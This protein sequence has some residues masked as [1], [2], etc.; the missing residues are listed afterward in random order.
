MTPVDEV[1][2]V[3]EAVAVAGGVG[4]STPKAV[5]KV[6]SAVRH[7][8]AAATTS[9]RTLIERLTSVDRNPLTRSQH[10]KRWKMSSTIATTRATTR[11]TRAATSDA[12]R[13]DRALVQDN[14]EKDNR[15]QARTFNERVVGDVDV[16]DVADAGMMPWNLDRAKAAAAMRS[17]RS[18]SEANSMNSIT[19][20]TA[21][22]RSTSPI[23]GTWRSHPVSMK[24][25]KGWRQAATRIDRVRMRTKTVDARVGGAAAAVVEAVAGNGVNAD[26]RERAPRHTAN[27]Q[28]PMIAMQ[29]ITTMTIVPTITWI[30]TTTTDWIATPISRATRL[31][32]TISKVTASTVKARMAIGFV[33]AASRPG[34]KRLATL[35]RRTWKRGPRTP[36]MV[37]AIAVRGLDKSIETAT[38][39][40]LPAC[41]ITCAQKIRPSGKAQG[42]SWHVDLACGFRSLSSQCGERR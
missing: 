40:E 6:M 4:I 30:G 37:I 26:L 13:L 34:T 10:R 17:R 39:R 16:A 7:R 27:V 3:V 14:R 38:S 18:R 15:E 32:V 19:P 21:I 24:M 25:R 36:T 42:G 41:P 11:A 2:D 8:A 29:T 12:E 28:P 5:V 20:S 22:W 23:G 33:T 1:A 9:S 31:K 35:S